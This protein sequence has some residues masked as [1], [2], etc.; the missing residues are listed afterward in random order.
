M[1]HQE[2]SEVD[3]PP[4]ELPEDRTPSDSNRSTKR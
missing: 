4:K 3:H 1:K 2:S